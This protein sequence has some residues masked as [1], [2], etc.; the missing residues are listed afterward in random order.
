MAEQPPRT[1]DM[2]DVRLPCGFTIKVQRAKLEKT[3]AFEQ[4]SA[5]CRHF[6]PKRYGEACVIKCDT[7][8]DALPWKGIRE[9]IS[10]KVFGY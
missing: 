3:T 5:F 6:C 8:R 2:M 7:L 9:S 4:W 1:E 10:G